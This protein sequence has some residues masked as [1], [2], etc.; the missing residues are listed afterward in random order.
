[1]SSSKAHCEISADALSDDFFF[2]LP[3]LA[4]SA[5]LLSKRWAN[6]LLRGEFPSI[7]WLFLFPRF[8]SKINYILLSQ[9]DPSMEVGACVNWMTQSHIPVEGGQHGEAISS[10]IFRTR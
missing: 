1:M 9:L 8:Q 4:G 5:F 7:K 10:L 3:Y 2:V 6:R